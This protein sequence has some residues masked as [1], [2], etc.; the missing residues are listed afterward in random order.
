MMV[1]VLV[2]ELK[3]EKSRTKMYNKKIMEDTTMNL[4]RMYSRPAHSPFFG[5]LLNEAFE[6]KDCRR[7]PAANIVD[8]DKAFE[9]SMLVPGI[10]KSDIQINL[11]KD[12]LT[13][14]YDAPEM[15][16][17]IN[18]TRRE[19]DTASFSRSF[20]LPDTIE[21]EKIQARHENGVLTIELPKKEAEVKLQ[22]EIAI[23]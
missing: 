10:A 20:I 16:D 23:A 21:R 15:Q 14:K 19:F 2:Q 5:S 4:V 7:N 11:E 17:E 12:V 8:S 13:V 6:M 9:I 1:L 18:Y 3:P 22:R